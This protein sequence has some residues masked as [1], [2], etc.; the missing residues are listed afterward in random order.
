MDQFLGGRSV[1]GYNSNLVV[2]HDYD[3]WIR[4]LK[5]G[6]GHNLNKVLGV[7]RIHKESISAKKEQIMICEA[8]QVQLRL[9]HFLMT[10]VNN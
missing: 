1:G 8:F 3:L 10:S 6:K 2:A 4:L 7:F 9:W 5:K